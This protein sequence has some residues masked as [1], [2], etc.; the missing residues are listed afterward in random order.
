MK[1]D[2]YVIY[3]CVCVRVCERERE[4]ESLRCVP[5]SNEI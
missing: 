2:I 5:E 1:K 4:R 3:T